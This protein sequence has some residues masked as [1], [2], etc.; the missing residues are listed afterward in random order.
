MRRDLRK[1]LSLTAK[2]NVTAVS[3]FPRNEEIVSAVPAEA[4]PSSLVAPTMFQ[5]VA[6]AQSL[7]VAVSVL[8]AHLWCNGALVLPSWLCCLLEQ[9]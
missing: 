7:F 1:R 2:P 9:S 3:N 5:V 8:S 6:V 4:S